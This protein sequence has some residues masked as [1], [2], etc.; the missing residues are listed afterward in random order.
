MNERSRPYIVIWAVMNNFVALKVHTEV[1]SWSTYGCEELLR[2]CNMR[3]RSWVI[4][5]RLLR[6]SK[7]KW[8]ASRIWAWRS[9]WRSPLYRLYNQ[10]FLTYW[11]EQMT[12][13]YWRRIEFKLFGEPVRQFVVEIGKHCST[14][15]IWGE[16]G[17]STPGEKVWHSSKSIWHLST[18]N[19]NLI[20]NRLYGPVH[21][22]KIHSNHTL[23]W[24][25]CQMLYLD[26]K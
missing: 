16:S 8:P 7:S 11:S 22:R 14:T 13:T 6:L 25:I 21:H 19:C 9:G 10:S 1:E 12:T 26:Y 5:W 24:A 18:S 15:S 4:M 3:W 20:R 23:H 2:K 17:Q